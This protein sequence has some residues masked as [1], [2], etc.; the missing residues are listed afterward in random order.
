MQKQPLARPV[1]PAHAARVGEPL[2]D[3]VVGA[4]VVGV[5]VVGDAL[6]GSAYGSSSQI[7]V[8]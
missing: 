7:H 3:T 8:V 6:G 4:A 2:G 1:E 5:A